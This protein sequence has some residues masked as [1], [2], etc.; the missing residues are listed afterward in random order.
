MSG[1][2]GKRE[3]ELAVLISY[4]WA[5]ETFR[6]LQD[7][8]HMHDPREYLPSAAGQLATVEI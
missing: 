2:A 1:K 5:V 6:R 7:L 3:R 8:V 4:E